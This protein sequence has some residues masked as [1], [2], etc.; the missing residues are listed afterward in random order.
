MTLFS[1]IIEGS[2]PCYKITEDD[3]F[4]S[5]LDIMPL[6]KGHCLVVPKIEIDRIFD[7]PLHFLN[8]Y[9]LFCQ[10][11]AHAIKKTFQCDRV[12]IVTIGL[13]VPHCHIHLIPTNSTTDMDFSQKKL[14][15]T[16]EEFLNI[17]RAIIAN[18]A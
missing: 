13:E 1:K 9:L 2:I 15:L 6:Q 18:L 7:L 16:K 12:N 8:N 11:I 14:S 3:L 10:P 5:F 17:Q 4:L